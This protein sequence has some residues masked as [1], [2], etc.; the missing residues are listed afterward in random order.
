MELAVQIAD[1]VKTMGQ[2]ISSLRTVLAI[3]GSQLQRG[4]EP[5][6]QIVIGTPG[7]VLDW[8]TK[9]SILNLKKIKVFVLDEADVM[10]DQQGHKEFCIRIVK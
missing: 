1:V 8:S 2:F 9:L 6:E 10:I 3:K 4:V 7:T 5:K